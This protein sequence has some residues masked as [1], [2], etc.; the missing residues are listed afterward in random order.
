MEEIKGEGFPQKEEGSKMTY[1]ELVRAIAVAEG[2]RSEV[3][4]G[5]IREILGILSDLYVTN[6]VELEKFLI[7]NGRR[8]AKRRGK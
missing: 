3:K 8:R 1:A 4:V 7:T 6:P 2:M 5:D